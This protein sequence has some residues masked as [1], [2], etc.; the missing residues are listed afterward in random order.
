[1]LI[2][3]IHLDLSRIKKTDIRIRYDTNRLMRDALTGADSCTHPS[4]ILALQYW[5]RLTEKLYHC[6]LP[7]C[8]ENVNLTLMILVTYLAIFFNNHE[9]KSV[10][11]RFFATYE[12]A[13]VTSCL[14]WSRAVL[15][16]TLSHNAL[17]MFCCWRVNLQSTKCIIYLEIHHEQAEN[18]KK[19]IVPSKDNVLLEWYLAEFMY[20]KSFGFG[21]EE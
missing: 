16:S 14:I 15:V 4:S 7:K 18:T 19:R 8:S 2:H 10:P 12:F 13:V 9:F 6:H 21:C 5:L 3:T 1:M 17:C 11:P 20:E